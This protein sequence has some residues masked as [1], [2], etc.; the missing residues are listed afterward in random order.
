MFIVVVQ[1]VV[2]VVVLALLL[3]QR[4]TDEAGHLALH[5]RLLPANQEPVISKRDVVMCRKCDDMLSDPSDEWV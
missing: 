5:P 4:L 2:V 1:V 3:L